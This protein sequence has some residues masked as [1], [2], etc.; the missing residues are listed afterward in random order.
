MKTDSLKQ[1]ENGFP[2]LSEFDECSRTCGDD[3]H[4]DLGLASAGPRSRTTRLRV[5]HHPGLPVSEAG[6]RLEL[7]IWVIMSRITLRD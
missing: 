7:L 1:L 2:S 5:S 3:Y 4:S 6:K